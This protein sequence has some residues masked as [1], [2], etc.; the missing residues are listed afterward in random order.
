LLSLPAGAAAEIV[1]THG[2]PQPQ[3]PVGGGYTPSTL[4]AMGDDGSDPHVL[5]NPSQV[6]S[7]Q[8]SLCCA[9]LQPDSSTMVFNGFDFQYSGSSAG[10]FGA[11]YE[12]AYVLSGGTLTRLS[13]Q[14]SDTPGSDS[15]DAPAVLTADGRVVYERIVCEFEVGNPGQVSACESSLSA[16]GEGGGS[17]S[18]WGW[19]GARSDRRRTRSQ[20]IRRTR[21]FW[22]TPTTSR[23]R[24]GTSC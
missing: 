5:L 13:P 17:S 15:S 20:P 7:D 4:V 23:R 9:S 6:A 16:E 3:L 21:S 24:R 11:F 19:A 18:P 10:G 12:G 1:Y 8:L 14:P 22:R 2:Q